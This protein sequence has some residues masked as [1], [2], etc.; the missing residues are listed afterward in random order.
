MFKK[1][2]LIGLVASMIVWANIVF[3]QALPSHLLQRIQQEF[4]GRVVGISQNSPRTYQV[5][6]LRPNGYLV[7]VIVDGRTGQIIGVE[8]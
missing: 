6:I 3:A 1:L 8:R 2:G 7:V 5:Q 4:G